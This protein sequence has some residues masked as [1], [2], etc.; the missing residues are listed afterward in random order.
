MRHV[1]ANGIVELPEPIEDIDAAGFGVLVMS[2]VP[3]DSTIPNELELGKLLARIHSIPLPAMRLSAQESMEL[4][5]LI[6]ERLKRRWQELRHL[7]DNLPQLP[8]AEVLKTSLESV[9]GT[10][11][12]LHMDF[13]QANFRM[14]NGKVIALLDWSN[15]LIGHPALELARIAETG[16]AGGEFLKGYASIK[17]LPTVPPWVETIFHLDTATMLALVF[18]SEEPNP[19]RAPAAINRVRELHKRL[20]EE[21]GAANT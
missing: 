11:Q 7:V 1:K 16:E 5:E 14:R 18:L 8:R 12:L 3:N 19:D 4:P 10:R 9:R 15:A 2:Y 13:R 21:L 6:P 17:A 20:M